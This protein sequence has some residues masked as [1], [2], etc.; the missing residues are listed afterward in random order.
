MKEKVA[1]TLQI[2]WPFLDET[3]GGKEFQNGCKPG[4]RNI[5]HLFIKTVFQLKAIKTEKNGSTTWI[6][7][8]L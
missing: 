3:R 8:Y 5:I 1:F 2:E 4:S 6:R 7:Q